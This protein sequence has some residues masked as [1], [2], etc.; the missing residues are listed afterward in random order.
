M[1]RD[2]YKTDWHRYNLKRKIAGLP[3]VSVE[4]FE[5]LL[6]EQRN[7]EKTEQEDKSLYCKACAKLFKTINAHDNHLNSKKHKVARLK[8]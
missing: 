4:G 3:P 8:I 1:Q 5:K 7:A 6:S 2:H